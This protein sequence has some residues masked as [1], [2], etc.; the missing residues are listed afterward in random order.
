MDNL[1]FGYKKRHSTS[2]AIF[3]VKQ[4]IEYFCRHGSSVYASFLD[5]TKGFDR[6]SHDGLFM[7]LIDRGIP[8]CWLRVLVY[9]YSN[10]SSVVKWQTAM[11]DSFLV[12]SGVRQGGVLSARFWA[13][14]MDELVLQ[15]RNTGLGCYIVNVFVACILY[16]DDVCLLAPTK[17]ALQRLLD[18]CGSYA[19]MWCIQYNE[20][21]TKVM[22]FGK[23][24]G[25]SSGCS[26]ILNNKPLDFVKEWKY[27][28]I[29]VVSGSSF[30]CSINKC[31]ATFYRSANSI[32]NVVR[33]PSECVMMKILYDIS[34]PN[35][36]YASEAVVFSAR[37]M[38]RLHVALNDAI[39]KIFTF[40][41]WESVKA[42]REGCGYPSVTE[43]FAKRKQLFTQKMPTLGNT[44]LTTILNVE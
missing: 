29:T 6:V 30:S 7:K 22:C 9:W 14:Y 25:L 26:L 21:K 23:S 4:C 11:S 35:L 13:V 2:H 33:R 10:L 5:C 44:V 19:R 3:T 8:L 36:T 12:I 28:G 31:L 43:I 24:D 20:K 37:E 27:L 16:A 38:N 40:A 17:K 15:L 32:L 41:R 39:R 18:I 42:L 34:V 1:Q